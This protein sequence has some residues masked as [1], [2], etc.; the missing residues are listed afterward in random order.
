[1]G[2]TAFTLAKFDKGRIPPDIHAPGRPHIYIFEAHCSRRLDCLTTHAPPGAAAATVETKTRCHRA[3]P[4]CSD[5]SS[6]APPSP[7]PLKAAP[8]DMLS[9]LEPHARTRRR[10]RVASLPLPPSP[11][12]RAQGM[13]PPKASISSCVRSSSDG[14][15]AWSASSAKVSMS[16]SSQPG[17]S[18]MRSRLT[19]LRRADSTFCGGAS[20]S[21]R[22]CC[23]VG[24]SRRRPAAGASGDGGGGGEGSG[25]S[26]LGGGGE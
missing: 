9:A 18:S 2:A 8:R 5:P 13:Y 6:S 26:G 23:G 20:P 17:G 10:W 7:F 16:S 22:C 24:S 3:R 12:K 25:G 21:R 14:N 1:M 4:D 15:V 19:T 11:T